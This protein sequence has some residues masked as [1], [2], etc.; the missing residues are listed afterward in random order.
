MLD[1][2]IVNAGA[3]HGVYGSD[4]ADSLIAVEP[5]LWCRLIAGYVRDHGFSVEIIDGEAEGM[6]PESIAIEAA[7][8]APRLVC[9]A[10]YGHQPSASTQQMDAA[11]RIAALIH[12]RTAG[13]QA[14]ILVGGHVAALPEQ[15]LRESKATFACNGEGPE[16]VLRLLQKEK[17][18]LTPS[19][20]DIPGLVWHYPYDLTGSTFKWEVINNPPAELIDV[21]KLHGNAWDLLPMHKYRAHNWQ[22]FDNLDSRQ[23]YASVYTSLGCPYACSFCCINSPFGKRLYRP[24]NPMAVAGEMQ[25]LYENYGVKTFKIVDEMFVLNERHYLGVA[26]EIINQLPAHELNIWAYSRVDTVKSDNLPIL[27]N[28]GFK[29]LAL[30]IES[31]SA[32]VRDGA[33]KRLK[34]DDIEEVV[35]KIQSY[36][37]NVI[38][39]FIFGLPDDTMDTMRATLDLALRLNCEFANFYSAMAYPGSPL[40]DEA[41]KKG[42]TLPDSWKGYSQHNYECRPLDTR[43][44][45]AAEVLKFRD[46]AFQIYFRNPKYIDMIDR[47]FGP[48]AALHVRDMTKFKLKR[49]LIEETLAPEYACGGQ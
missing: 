29:W 30:G 11:L 14:Q 36:D 33:N 35:R 38:G 45:K 2:L 27:R 3:A 47:K 37:I 17:P 20:A 25:F 48:R 4:L 28:A 49:R 23:P 9:I 31:E 24:R 18:A 40:Y 5:P 26:K 34:R 39:N 43:H 1:L 19:Y 44:V 13:H 41:V 6:S 10:V 7:L 42:W 22:C 15:T 16:T 8:E 21:N 32:Y 46:E 12:E